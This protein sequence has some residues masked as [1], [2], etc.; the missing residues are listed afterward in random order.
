MAE[1]PEA[2]A[3]ID[4]PAARLARIVAASPAFM[5]Q[6]RAVR[7]L[8]LASWCIGA[9]ALRNLVWDHLHGHTEASACR[10]VDVAYFEPADAP[11]RDERALQ[12]AL[13]SLLP[14]VPWEVTDQARVHEW[15]EQT[16]GHPVAPLR[17]LEEAVASWPEYATAVGVWLDAAGAVQVI[18]PHGLDDLFAQRIRRNPAR[19]SVDTYRQRVQQKQYT[20]R[21]PAVTID[22]C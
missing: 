5:A 22:A 8:R 16:F 2:P 7:S 18:A 4:T 9:G 1:A 17:S 20:R 14:G 10:D 12:A 15:F 6:L 19:V 13:Q 11:P 21:W 3:G